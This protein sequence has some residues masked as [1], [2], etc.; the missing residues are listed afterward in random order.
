MLKME[1]VVVEDWVYMKGKWVKG[2]EFLLEGIIFVEEIK[3]EDKEGIFEK[4][5]G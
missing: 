2:E 3:E 1:R 4:D 5:E